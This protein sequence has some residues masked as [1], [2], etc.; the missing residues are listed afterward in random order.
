[1]FD[2]QNVQIAVALVR[3]PDGAIALSWNANWD[4]FV[5]PVSKIDPGPPA[6]SAEQAAI[7]AAAEAF[8]VPCRVV[9]GKSARAM[10]TLQL[11]QRD[12]QIK[13]YNFTVVPIEVHP[14]FQADRAWNDRCIFVDVAKALAGD[15]QP[16]SPSVKPIVEACLEWEWL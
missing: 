11:G 6:E 3:R 12:G 10:R 13:D 14:D 1:M 2:P 9:P 8:Q 5:M 16:L 7:R 4:V 15:Y